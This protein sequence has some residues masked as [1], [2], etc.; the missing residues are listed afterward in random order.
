[1]GC[2]GG[3]GGI[4][5]LGLVSGL[6]GKGDVGGWGGSWTDILAEAFP[7]GAFTSSPDQS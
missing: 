7:F 1:M 3:F 6:R 4:S 2:V 5:G